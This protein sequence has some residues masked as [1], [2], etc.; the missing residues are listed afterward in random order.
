MLPVGP[1]PSTPRPLQNG[2]E[3][4]WTPDNNSG[5]VGATLAKPLTGRYKRERCVCGL[6]HDGPNQFDQLDITLCQA[7]LAGQLY[8]N[9]V[10]DLSASCASKIT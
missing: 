6:R 8:V 1:M 5:T 7:A 2:E 9:R 3:F 4:D 10:L